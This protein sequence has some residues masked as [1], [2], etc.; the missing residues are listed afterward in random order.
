MTEPEITPG[1]KAD[2][3][4]ESG[5]RDKQSGLPYEAGPHDL[6]EAVEHWDRGW[7]AAEADMRAAG[8]AAEQSDRFA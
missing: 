2:D 1:M 4:Y 6:A 8:R 5:Y 7:Y 3:W